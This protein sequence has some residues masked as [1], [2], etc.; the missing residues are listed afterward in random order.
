[1]SSSTTPL[2]Y[3]NIMGNPE[4]Q[5]FEFT[6]NWIFLCVVV[7]VCYSIPPIVVFGRIA[8]FFFTKKSK[9]KKNVLRIEIFYS[10]LLMQ[11]WN[12]VLVFADFAMFRMPY[13]TIFTRYCA[14]ENPQTL[15]KCI[16]FVY[17]W[18]AYAFQLFT[19]LFCALRVAILYLVS[20]NTTERIMQVLPPIIIIFGLAAAL[21]HFSTDAYCMQLVEPYIY[22]SVLII[23][24]FHSMNSVSLDSN[25][26][27]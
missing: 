25:R 22:G 17:F 16:V 9:I 27:W 3:K 8:F 21:P 18:A 15:L 4:Y 19:V 24:K 7:M 12:I 23:S 2:S 26:N 13:T 1:M 10:F 6:V 20:K 11:F 5:N 14:A